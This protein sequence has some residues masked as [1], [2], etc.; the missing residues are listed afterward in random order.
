MRRFAFLLL[1]STI[2]ASPSSL[3]AD[4]YLYVIDGRAITNG[5][6]VDNK[7]LKAKYSGSYFWFS[8]DG[9]AYI[10]RD[11]KVLESMKAI[12]LPIFDLGID[13]TIGEQ[14]PLMAQQLMLMKEQLNIGLDPKPGEDPAIAARRL[15]LKYEQNRL[16]ARQ[17]ELARRAND[18]ARKLNA[19]AARLDEINRGIERRL[20]D[21]GKHLIA[22][23][24]AVPA[25]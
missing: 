17:N 5:E 11:P 23:R 8:I 22:L 14:L 9:K 24:I 10:A 16:A 15:E 21:L 25:D 4:S 13:F 19:Y 3:L 7:E 1:A 18:S 12:Y 2:L 6:P 20:H